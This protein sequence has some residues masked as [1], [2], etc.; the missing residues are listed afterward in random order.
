MCFPAGEFII[1]SGDVLL[2][3]VEDC[4]LYIDGRLYA[5]VYANAPGLI[6]DVAP[7]EPEGFSLGPGDGTRF[8]LR[9]QACTP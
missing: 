3:E 1:G 7:G 9:T 2:G 8:V 4:P 5:A 6:L